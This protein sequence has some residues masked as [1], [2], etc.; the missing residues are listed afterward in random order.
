MLPSMRSEIIYE[1]TAAMVALSVILGAIVLSIMSL[2]AR[3]QLTDPPGWLQTAVGAVI[4]FY[5]ARRQTVDDRQIIRTLSEV[6]R[7]DGQRAV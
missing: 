5:F 1:L 4:G 6:Q 2:I 3:G 7:Q